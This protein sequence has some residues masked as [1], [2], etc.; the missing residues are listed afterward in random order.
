MANAGMATA[1]DFSFQLAAID[2]RDL[3]GR[4]H[5]GDSDEANVANRIY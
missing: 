3:A 1:L 2:Q 4:A 5:G